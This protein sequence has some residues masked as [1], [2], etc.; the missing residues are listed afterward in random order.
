M[1]EQLLVVRCGGSA[2]EFEQSFAGDQGG[3]VRFHQWANWRAVTDLLRT[4]PA[5]H[6][7]FFGGADHLVDGALC[8][9][10]QEIDR[11]PKVGIVYGDHDFMDQTGKRLA[12]FRK[13]GWS[14]DRLQT[15]MYL[16]RAAAYRTDLVRNALSSAVTGQT[17]HLHSLALLVS[18]VSESVLH[19]PQLLLHLG[20]EPQMLSNTVD[21][22]AVSS[23]LGRCRIQAS[24]VQRGEVVGLEPCLES[25][26]SVSLIVPTA[27]SVQTLRGK[28]QRLVDNL[29]RSIDETTSYADLELIVVADRTAPDDL[30]DRLRRQTDLNLR[31]VHNSRPFHFSEASNLGAAHSAAEVLVFLNDDVE[32]PQ[33]DWLERLVVRVLSPGVGA[34]GPRLLFADGRI[35]HAGVWARGGLAAHRYQGFAA[36]HPGAFGALRT[37]QTC[38]AVT[39]ACLAVMRYNFEAVGGFST[40]FPLNYNDYDLCLKLASRG[41]RSVVDG[42]TTLFHYESSTRESTVENWEVDRFKAR[43]DSQLWDHPLD[44][45]HHVGFWIEEYPGPSAEHTETSERLR[46]RPKFSSRL[47][48]NTALVSGGAA[49][50]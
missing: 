6:V 2:L 11:H 13:P 28:S 32:V 5:S 4:S 34:V 29:V 1:V 24:A 38:V 14:P 39:G 31:F 27:G 22:N 16:D 43:W 36:D 10:L 44:N 25:F 9:M 20:E 21:V 18:E 33:A 15:Q 12:P 23:H 45:P 17:L 49:S 26:P 40:D 19:V 8:R 42:D 3:R 7:M 46:N 35:Q 41:L 50:P 30:E 47:V 48:R 37:S